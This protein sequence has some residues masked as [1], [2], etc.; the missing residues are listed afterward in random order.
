[1]IKEIK[2]AEHEEDEKED[3][4]K[5]DARYVTREEFR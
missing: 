5:V 1:M 3:E 4:E 2:N